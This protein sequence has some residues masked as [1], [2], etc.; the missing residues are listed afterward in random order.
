MTWFTASEH[1][2]RMDGA[3]PSRAKFFGFFFVSWQ[4]SGVKMRIRHI[5]SCALSVLQMSST[6]SRQIFFSQISPLQF[7]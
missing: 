1:A 2:E 3:G 5:D 4:A 6:A 7:C